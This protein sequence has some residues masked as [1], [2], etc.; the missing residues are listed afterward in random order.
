MT[1]HDLGIDTLVGDPSLFGL[2]G[3]VKVERE[4]PLYDPRFRTLTDI[5]V[6]YELEDSNVAIA[7]L[8]TNTGSS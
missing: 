6:L 2:D 7:E 4:I 1:P 8:K 3:V 5:D